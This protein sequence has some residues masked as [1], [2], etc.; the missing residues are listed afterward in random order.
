MHYKCLTLLS[1]GWKHDT[2]CLLMLHTN[3][4]YKLYYGNIAAFFLLFYSQIAGKSMWDDGR[5]IYLKV[6][7]LYSFGSKLSCRQFVLIQLLGQLLE[8]CFL[9]SGSR[10]REEPHSHLTLKAHFCQSL[11]TGTLAQKYVCIPESPRKIF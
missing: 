4:K 6:L 8:L 9:P 2:R 11:D 3:R 5:S 1:E 10:Q 7:P